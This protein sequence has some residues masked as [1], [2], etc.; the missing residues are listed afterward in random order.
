[1][2]FARL[3]STTLAS[4]TRR[5]AT[6]PLLSIV[7]L[8]RADT[9]A[10]LLPSTAAAAQSPPPLLRDE[11]SQRAAAAA[12][13]SAAAQQAAGALLPALTAAWT[14]LPDLMPSILNVG[15]KQHNG[16]NSRKPKKANHG[17]LP[18][19]HVMRRRRA[20]AAGRLRP[21]IR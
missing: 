15:K 20:A 8:R 19:S 14:L 18:C 5:V 11:S 17:A 21:K 4:V 3:A 9:A 2:L 1:M 6:S 10:M 13:G 16:K 12:A 7:A